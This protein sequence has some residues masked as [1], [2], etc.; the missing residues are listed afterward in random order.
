MSGNVRTTSRSADEDLRWLRKSEHWGEWTR[1][2]DDDPND[3][4]HVWM[5]RHRNGKV[6]FYEVGK[7]QVGP[8]CPHVVAAVYWAYAH[9]FMA[10]DASIWLNIACRKEVMA[11]GI[12]QGLAS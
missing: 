10:V 7:G 1:V 3:V 11:G 9:W 8:E 6:R 4:Q 5:M 12:D 2:S